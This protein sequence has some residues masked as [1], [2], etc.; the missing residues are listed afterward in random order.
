MKLVRIL[1]LMLFLAG[2]LNRAFAVEPDIPAPVI[3][4]IHFSGNSEINTR[5]LC[6]MMITKQSNFFAKR[7]LDHAQLMNDL[8]QI[9]FYYRNSGF[10]DAEI[11]NYS[12]DIDSSKNTC[13][14]SIQI[15]EGD[16]TLISAITIFNNTVFSDE[17]VLSLIELQVG[18]PLNRVKK[19]ASVRRILREYGDSGYMD[20]MVRTE[21]R[22]N[23]DANE[24]IV[25]FLIQENSQYSISEIRIE[26]LTDTRPEVIWREVDLV[27]GD[28]IR[29]YR[30][31]ELQRTLYLTGLFETVSVRPVMPISGALGK[32]DILIQITE[33]MSQ[34]F[35]ISAG[36]GTLDIVRTSAEWHENS[37]LGTSR[38]LGLE[39]SASF[40]QRSMELSYSDPWIL[41]IPWTTDLRAT[42]EFQDQPGYD[43]YRVMG[44]VNVG[45][46]LT[47]TVRIQFGYRL[48]NASICNVEVEE[49]EDDPSV[50]INAITHD[51]IIDTRDNLFNPRQGVYLQVSHEW[52][53]GFPSGTETFFKSGVTLR[54]VFT[55]IEGTTIAS[56]LEIGGI[57]S[58]HGL[59]AIPLTERLYAGGP[60]SVRAYGYQQ[61]GPLD[62]GH[63]PLGGRFRVVCNPLEMRQHVVG[64]FGI[65]GFI[66]AGLVTE[67][68]QDARWSDLLSGAGAGIR[69]DTPVG[70]ARLDFALPVTPRNLDE[71][72]RIWFGIGQAY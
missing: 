72:V 23:D 63:D 45:H 21:V 60:S 56:G 66:D 61:V 31:L 5:M 64:I 51:F 41:G 16:A 9:R 58:H 46:S 48:E 18:E 8:D 28:T 52:A 2:M 40:L 39:G 26:G 59:E 19:D 22:E 7:R 47:E 34:E 13:E 62:D 67:S 1:I 69:A 49:V 3:T 37:L 43:V 10:L 54:S 20:A 32:K 17:H 30:L 38:K 24:A 36:M 71:P 11:P 14:I 12:V 44:E 27:P 68:I 29:Y 15:V 33:L 55:P 65:A 42:W 50:Q 53:G 57:I 70:M 35:A 6:R 25:D 4:A